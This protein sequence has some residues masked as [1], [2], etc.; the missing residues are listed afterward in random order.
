M[1]TILFLIFIALSLTLTAKEL[2]PQIEGDNIIYHLTV[3]YKTVNFTGKDKRAMAVNNSIPAPTLR[4]E[5]GKNAVIYVTNKMD[6]ETSIHWHGL[7]LPN[8]QD[9]VPYLNSPPIQPNKTYKFEFPLNQSGTYWYH[10]HTGLQEQRG[11]YGSII[12]EPKEKK[13][14]YDHDL[15]IVLSDWTDEN[16]NEVLRTLKRGSEWYSIRKDSVQS[17]NRVIMKGALWAQLKMWWNRMPGMDISDIYYDA[18]LINGK[19]KQ[20]YSEFKPGDKVRIRV[21]NAATSTYFT[22]SFG[23]EDPI[24]ISA[25]GIDVVPTKTNKVLQAIAETYDF[26]VTI[27][28]N[29][30]LEFK[31]FAQDG[32]GVTSAIL[33][34]GKLL[35]APIIPKPDLIK[36]MKKMANMKKNMKMKKGMKMKKFSYNSLKATKKTSFSKDIPVKKIEMNLTG[37]MWRYIWSMDNKVLSESDKI[38]IKK[39]EIVRITLNNKTMMHHPMHLHGHFFRVLNKNGEYSPLKHTVD[40]PPMGKVVIEFDA[41]EVGDWFFHCHVLYH[42]KAGMARVFSYGTTRDKRLKGYALSNILNI[43]NNFFKWGDINLMSNRADLSLT[44]SN[45]RNMFLFDSTFSWFDNSYKLSEKYEVTASY[46]RFMSN[47]FRLYM[48]GNLE[49][50]KAN[51]LKD[52][53]LTGNIGFRYLLPFFIDLDISIDNNIKPQI[54]LNY[55]ILLFPRLELALDWEWEMNFGVIEKLPKDKKWEQNFRWNIGLNYILSKDFSIIGNYDNSFGWGM[56]INWRL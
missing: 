42:M 15:V 36:Q 30:S 21:I 35:K 54:A 8:F 41:N 39:G 10:S 40:V 2:S 38:K 47:Y 1:K 51:N 29:N 49:N 43:D 50:Q 4:F 26:I 34:K 48:G 23:G 18:F 32:S 5:E 53:D 27:P 22:L 33:G 24:L 46:E 16:P 17:L 31:A 28:E 25:D 37:N 7:I 14:A 45:T 9:G 6:T 12:I 3:D 52:I 19:R 11:V 20:L 55:E 13:I 44:L 56:G